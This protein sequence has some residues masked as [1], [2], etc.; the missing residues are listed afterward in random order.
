MLTGILLIAAGIAIAT[1]S[2][3]W[4]SVSRE[5]GQAQ[6]EAGRQRGVGRIYQRLLDFNVETGPQIGAWLG[7]A[8]GAAAIVVGVV[9][10]VSS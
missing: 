7:R 10:V 1:F 5:F 9:L 4:L 3:A 8:V 2:G 6:S